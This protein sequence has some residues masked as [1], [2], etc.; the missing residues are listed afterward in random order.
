MYHLLLFSFVWPANHP[1]IKRVALCH[2]R[3][4]DYITGSTVIQLWK[5]PS[6]H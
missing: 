5:V 6:N 3:T 4:D 1:T 2:K